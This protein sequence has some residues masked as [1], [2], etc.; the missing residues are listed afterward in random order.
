MTWYDGIPGALLFGGPQA[1]YTAANAAATTAQ[2]LIAQVSGNFQQPSIPAGFF[3]VGKTGQT[4]SG[5]FT[6]IVTGQATATT[7]TLILG[8]ASAAQSVAGTTLITGP[9]L[10]VTSLSNAGWEFD[11]E[12]LCRGTGQGTSANSTVL[13][14]TGTCSAG[15]VQGVATPTT[16]SAVDATAVNWLYAT[17]TFSTAS[18]TNSAQLQKVTAYAFV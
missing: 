16:V 18:A 15:T 14:T 13:L 3:Q 7:M 11:F 10:T 1:N 5:R 4:I 8:Y 6:G 17:V 9:A 2:S 12:I